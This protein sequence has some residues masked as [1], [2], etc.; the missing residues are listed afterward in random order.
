MRKLSLTGSAVL[1]LGMAAAL[2]GCGSSSPNAATT[3]A[4]RKSA[5][6]SGNVKIDKASTNVSTAA[7]FLTVLK[8]H[9]SALTAMD[10]NLPSGTLGSEARQ[11]I[12]AADSAIASG[13]ANDL[14]NAPSSA[15][16]DID[17][18]CGVNGSGDPLP[19]YFAT[20]KGST[21]CTTFLPIYEAVGNATSSA[22]V[23]AALNANK[24]EITQLASEV[25]GLP[26]SI[27]AKASTVV[28]KAQTAL[29]ENNAASLKEN[30][31]GPASALALY[32]GQNQ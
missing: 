23:L 18:Y 13:N 19:A 30:G 28:S 14:N 27:R 9:K 6:C 2:A 25:P 29:A 26:S 5:F 3:A 8:D 21:F 16:G 11:E 32:C 31:N 15:G 7:G 20:G 17:T 24:T 22:A 10:Q 12:S 4:A 1:A